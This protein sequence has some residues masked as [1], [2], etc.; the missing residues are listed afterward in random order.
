[1]ATTKPRITITMESHRHELLRRL[2]ELTGQSM[3][4]IVLDM[5]ETVAPVLERV[6]VALESAKRAQQG[7]KEN[8]RRVAEESEQA[9]LPHV[10]AAMGQLDIF[11]TQVTQMAEESAHAQGAPGEPGDGR[12]AA[13]PGSAGAPPA[14]SD[15]RPVITGVRSDSKGASAGQ[16]VVSNPRQ[17]KASSDERGEKPPGCLCTYTKHERQE[18]R[19]CPVHDIRGPQGASADKG[20]GGRSP[21]APARSEGPLQVVRRRRHAV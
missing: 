7:V 17:R 5:I 6:A 16:R 1:M 20:A 8:L 10:E 14:E 12:G 9:F 11:L 2:S 21:T 18:H 3:S 15:P 4:S 13:A 19:D